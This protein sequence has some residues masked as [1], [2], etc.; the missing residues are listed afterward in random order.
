MPNDFY[1]GHDL[2]DAV[3]SPLDQQGLPEHVRR[4]A[5]VA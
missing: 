2:L 3:D 4:D 1:G 5:L